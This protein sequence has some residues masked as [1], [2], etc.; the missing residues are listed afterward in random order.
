MLRKP[1]LLEP[2]W[3]T[4]PPPPP[5]TFHHGPPMPRSMPFTTTADCLMG[6]LELL[7]SAHNVLALWFPLMFAM[8]CCLARLCIC[9]ALLLVPVPV[10]LLYLQLPV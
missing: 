8:H 2:P 7:K 10:G 3:S 4:A 6:Q 1:S 9:Q 5:H